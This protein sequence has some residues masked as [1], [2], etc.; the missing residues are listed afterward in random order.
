MEKTVKI[1]SIQLSGLW[2]SHWRAAPWPP[3]SSESSPILIPVSLTTSTLPG[4]RWHPLV[5]SV[6]LHWVSCSLATELFE[7]H[8]GYE[9]LADVNICKYFPQAMGYLFIVVSLSVQNSSVWY[10]TL[11]LR[12]SC[13]CLSV[14]TQRHHCLSL[15]SWRLS[16]MSFSSNFIVSVLMLK[17]LIPFE[18][19]FIHSVRQWSNFIFLYIAVQFLTFHLAKTPSFSLVCVPGTFTGVTVN[20]WV[21]LWTLLCPIGLCICSCARSI[22]FRLL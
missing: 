19:T 17:S 14:H 4:V 10:S 11:C 15:G 13:L 20:A 3:L 6:L 2:Q 16:P 12:L 21:C 9:P 5:T 1:G 18:L 8:F 7:P 22:L